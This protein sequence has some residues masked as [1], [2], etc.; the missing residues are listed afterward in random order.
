MDKI[1]YFEN[2]EFGKIRIVEIDGRPYFVASDIAKSLG[3]VR[4]AD[5][6]S[7]HCRYT[8]KHRIPHPQSKTKTLEV[9]VIPEG[10]SFSSLSSMSTINK[11]PARR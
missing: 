3:Y 8:V 7:Q 11:S 10:D 2:K 5:A 1:K 9:N 6:I 4:P